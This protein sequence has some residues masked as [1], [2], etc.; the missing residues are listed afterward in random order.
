MS[1]D[2]N[3]LDEHLFNYGDLN[4]EHKKAAKEF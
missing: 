1:F 2:L 4:D 3:D